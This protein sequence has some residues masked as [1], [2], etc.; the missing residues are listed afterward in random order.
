MAMIPYRRLGA[1][2]G[3][4]Y[5]IALALMRTLVMKMRD[6]FCEYVPEGALTKEDQP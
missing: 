4:P 3:Y 2:R 5:H 6:V 1:W